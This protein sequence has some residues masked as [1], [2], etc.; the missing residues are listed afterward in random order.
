MRCHAPSALQV[1]VD[2]FNALDLLD[3]DRTLL[4]KLKFGEGDGHLQYYLYN[5]ACP[6]MEPKDVGLVLL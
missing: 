5:W 6:G 2:V 3:N 1:N 4:D